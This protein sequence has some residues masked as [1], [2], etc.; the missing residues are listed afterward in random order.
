MSEGPAPAAAGEGG[1]E[2]AGGRLRTARAAY[3]KMSEK[4][5]SWKSSLKGHIK[6]E[7]NCAKYS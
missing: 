1:G 7:Q 4:L 5:S 3:C 6:F 2:G